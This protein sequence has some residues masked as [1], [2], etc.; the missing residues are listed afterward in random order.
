MLPTDPIILL[1]YVN[2][3][4]RDEF[5]SLYDLCQSL[6]VDQAS[7]EETLLKINYQYSTTQNQFI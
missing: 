2:T 7:L 1:S 4:L 6:D 3:K 5:P